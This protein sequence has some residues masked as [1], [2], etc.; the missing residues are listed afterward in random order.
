MSVS[1]SNL[2]SLVFVLAE[3]SLHSFALNLSLG[4]IWSKEKIRNLLVRRILKS[5]WV[6]SLKTTQK[7][8]NATFYKEFVLQCVKFVFQNNNMKFNNKFYNQI[9]DTS[10]GTIFALTYAT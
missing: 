3:T 2:F 8:L 9:K 5:P 6:T 7:I 4:R 10:M 1:H